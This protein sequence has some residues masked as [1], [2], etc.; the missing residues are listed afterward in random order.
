MSNNLIIL[1]VFTALNLYFLIS[2]FRK[3]GGPAGTGSAEFI[4]RLTLGIVV[5]LG[6]A[7]IVLL[8]KGSGAP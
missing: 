8:W 4:I 6:L 2:R 5:V 3:S 1:I 7:G